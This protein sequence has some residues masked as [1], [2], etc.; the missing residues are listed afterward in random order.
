MNDIAAVVDPEVVTAPI[1]YALDTGELL[2]NETF[3]PNNI[4]RIT[5]APAGNTAGP[6]V[7]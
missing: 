3:G 4:R 7:T 1:S 2:V 5:P 6:G